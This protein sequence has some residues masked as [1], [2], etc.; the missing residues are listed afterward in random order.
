LSEDTQQLMM[1]KE[2]SGKKVQVDFDGG[3]VSSDGG[4]LFVHESEAEWGTIGRVVDVMHD[5]RHSGYVKHQLRELATQRVFQIISGYEDGND[6]N[7]LRD[8]PVMKMVCG[9]LPI[10]GSPLASQPTM[11]RFENSFSHA[12]LY[13]IAKV[14]LDVFIDSYQ[15]APEGIVLDFD[16]TADATHGHQQLTLFN[17]FHDTYCYM[18]LHVYEGKSGKLITTILR[19]G[20]R[21][22]GKEVTSILKRIVKAIRAAWPDVGIIFRGDSHY[23]SPEVF[24]YC[25]SHNVKYILGLTA[26]KPMMKRSQSL[27][28]QAQEFYELENKPI[29]RFG[30]FDYQANSWSVPQRVIVK[31]EHNE[32]GANTRFVVTNLEHAN[33]K[34]IYQGVYSDRGRMELMIKEHK[35]HLLSDRTSCCSF[36][37]NQFRL[38]LHSIAYVLL[39]S[40]REK[41]LRNTQFAAAQFNTIQKRLL[42]IGARVRQL[43]T[44]IKVSLPSSTPT[45]EEFYNIWRSC[46][47]QLTT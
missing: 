7:E 18:P 1:F 23:A 43:S 9:R 29:K 36:A 32:R 45:K 13:R 25:N 3:E 35:S 33:R 2:I 46:C 15:T 17:A 5:R 39:H 44:K 40:F 6:C 26:R 28:T 8:D 34:F 47:P 11:S 20:K 14:L 38:F 16:D 4:L 19:A 37:A 24:D 41:H 27:I 30:E 42:K 10:T 22:N 21:P 12:D 31:A